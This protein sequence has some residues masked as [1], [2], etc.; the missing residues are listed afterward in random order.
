MGN[1]NKCS[2]CKVRPGSPADNNARKS[3]R[4]SGATGPYAKRINGTYLNGGN[5][6]GDQPILFK[7][8]EVRDDLLDPHHI[9]YNARECSWM[10]APST[11]VIGW[12]GSIHPMADGWGFL[13]SQAQK[14]CR[15]NAALVPKG[16]WS[17]INEADSSWVNAPEVTVTELSTNE[18]DKAFRRWE[19]ERPDRNRVEAKAARRVKSVRVSGV[20]GWMGKRCNGVY[21]NSGELY[22]GKAK[23][24]KLVKSGEQD[25]YFIYAAFWAITPSIENVEGG[26]PAY[27]FGGQNES[28]PSAAQQTT[29][30]QRRKQKECESSNV[31]EGNSQISVVPLAS[32]DENDD[33]QQKVKVPGKRNKRCRNDAPS[34]THEEVKFSVDQPPNWLY[35]A[36]RT[37]PSNE[38]QKTLDLVRDINA[39]RPAGGGTL[40]TWAAEFHRYDIAQMLLKRG[41]DA[42]IKDKFNQKTA[43]EWAKCSQFGVDHSDEG[44]SDFVSDAR[45]ETIRV[46]TTPACF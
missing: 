18:T 25:L 33:E 35:D 41:A 31:W 8:D 32:F 45:D 6:Y 44:L 14:A 29:W 7:L 12:D 36:I 2:S 43:L 11:S 27:M 17:Q 46:L 24:K 40:L 10:M 3:I 20:T 22:N 1:I 16:M 38:V 26:S 21:V 28:D 4:I 19:H 23:L 13:C 9:R 34:C 5:T 37:L 15:S 42:K 30:N 39:Q